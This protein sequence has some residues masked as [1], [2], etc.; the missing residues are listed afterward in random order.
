MIPHGIIAIA[1]LLV[2]LSTL[3]TE[4]WGHSTSDPSAKTPPP[5]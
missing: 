1:F 2:L 5:A 4:R 3:V